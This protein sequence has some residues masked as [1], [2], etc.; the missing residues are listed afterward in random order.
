MTRIRLHRFGI[1]QNCGD[2]CGRSAA[3]EQRERFLLP[4][5]VKLF[6]PFLLRRRPGRQEETRDDVV[7]VGPIRRKTSE[8]LRGCS[9]CPE[10][11][12][13]RRTQR[14]NELARLSLWNK[15]GEREPTNRNRGRLYGHADC[16]GRTRDADDDDDDGWM[17]GG[18]VGVGCDR[19]SGLQCSDRSQSRSIRSRTHLGSR[20]VRK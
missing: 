3:S 18:I 19:N 13:E 1:F 9:K 6:F 11:Q 12:S 20:H 17:A 14:E 8:L 10:L 15:H 4:T 5:Y 16:V 2:R 7:V